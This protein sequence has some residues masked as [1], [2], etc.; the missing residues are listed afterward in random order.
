M[1]AESQKEVTV[2]NDS[3]IFVFVDKRLELDLEYI[4][5]TVVLLHWKFIYD[6]FYYTECP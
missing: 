4:S 5:V 1:C 3:H 6:L 2:L